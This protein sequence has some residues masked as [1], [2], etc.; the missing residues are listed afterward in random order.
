MFTRLRKITAAAIASLALAVS[1]VPAFAVGPL[2]NNI[3]SYAQ[4]PTYTASIAALTPAASA[5]DI[6]T[7]TGSATKTIWIRS[8]G[9]TGTST[10][11][12][13]QIVSAF[14]RGVVDT[15]GTSTA[16]TVMNLDSADPA[17]TA[18]VAAYTANPT[19]ASTGTF[20][21]VATGLLTT[22]APASV[23]SGAGLFFQENSTDL[24]RPITLH[25][26]S[27]QLALNL[28]GAS[29]ASGGSL[30]CTVTWTEH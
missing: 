1:V 26:T 19:I 21:I 27:Q 6:F 10:A 14:I 12:A 17:G 24:I 5:T 8:F 29:I 4:Y 9:C 23:N 20:G 25:G 11:A 2:S 22:V 18:T 3:T 28:G 13:S 7:I 30:T 15:S 16:P